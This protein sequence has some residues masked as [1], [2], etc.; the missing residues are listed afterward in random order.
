MTPS[1][2]KKGA[3]L[4]T[5]E[6]TSSMSQSKKGAKSSTTMP[7][8][9][10]GGSRAPSKGPSPAPPEPE[11]R[12]AQ[13]TEEYLRVAFNELFQC[14]KQQELRDR[15]GALNQEFYARERARKHAVSTNRTLAKGELGFLHS[16]KHREEKRQLA[17]KASDTSHF[18]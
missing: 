14:R 8:S 13:E 7:A 1:Q 3:E 5:T 4:S 16:K 9:A 11:K 17:Y 10:A 18:K 2:S 6:P 12:K 15:R